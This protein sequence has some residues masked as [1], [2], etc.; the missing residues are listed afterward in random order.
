MALEQRLQHSELEKAELARQ[1]QD[2]QQSSLASP[3]KPVQR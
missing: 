3:S 2:L 1:L